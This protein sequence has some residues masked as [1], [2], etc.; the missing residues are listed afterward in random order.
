MKRFINI[1]EIN[2]LKRALT[3]LKIL[4]KERFNLAKQLR[5]ISRQ[6]ILYN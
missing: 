6:E 5:F 2:P 4:S 3:S 1:S